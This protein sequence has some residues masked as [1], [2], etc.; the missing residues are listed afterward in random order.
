M[1]TM[2][3]VPYLIKMTFDAFGDLHVFELGSVQTVLSNLFWI[4]EPIKEHFI[5]FALPLIGLAHKHNQ[6]SKVRTME[7]RVLH[8]RPMRAI[9]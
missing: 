5:L 9:E 6:K 2:I 1:T 8:E 4:A 3:P 7:N